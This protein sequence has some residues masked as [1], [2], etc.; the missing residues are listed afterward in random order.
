VVEAGWA[1]A[2]LAAFNVSAVAW[3]AWA[4]AVSLSLRETTKE[5]IRGGDLAAAALIFLLALF[6]V[7][8]LNWIAVAGLA[9]YILGESPLESFRARG[10]LIFLALT[11]TMFWGPALME[12]IGAVLLRADAMLVSAVTDA[13]RVGN[14]LKMRDGSGSIEITPGCSSLHNISLGILAWV[15][16]SQ[17]VGR[18]FSLTDVGWALAAAGVT[19]LVNGGRLS[20]ISLGYNNL[21]LIHG[22]NGTRLVGLIVLALVGAVCLFGARREIF[23]RT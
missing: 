3:I 8:R 10:A 23:A 17:A 1:G 14:I 15:T 5:P 12:T 11:G 6:P 7:G 13:E 9:L 22:E 2:L 4:V 21:T 18:R 20:L 19:V 16:T